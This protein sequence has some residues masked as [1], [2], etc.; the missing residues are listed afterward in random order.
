MPA[1]REYHWKLYDFGWQFKN[2]PGVETQ[3]E[4]GLARLNLCP[5]GHPDHTGTL[6]DLGC[7]L[8]FYYDQG[9]NILDLNRAIEIKQAR[10]DLCPLDHP[11]ALG[12]FALTLWS[13]YLVQRDVT[14]L[15]R[16]I[17]MEEKMFDLHPSGHP[18]HDT[19]LANLASYLNGHYQKQGNLT[20]LSRAIGLNE[21]CLELCPLSHQDH[22]LVLY[23]LESTL[24]NHYNEVQKHS[25]L[26]RAIKMLKEALATYPVQH[27]SFASIAGELAAA[28]LLPFKS[29]LPDQPLPLDEA[30]ENYRLLKKCGPAVSLDLWDA[31]QAWVKD[32]EEHNHSSVL[33]AYQTS[34]NTL[35][36]FTSFNSF[37]D[38]RHETMQARM[39]DL[40][41]NAFSCA[42]RHGDFQMAIELLEQGRGILGNQLAH[43]DFSITALQSWGNRGR[44]LGRKYMRLSADLRKRA[45]GSGG[46]GIDPY[47]RVQEE[48]QSVV[49]EIQRL[50]GFSRFLLPPRFEDLQDAA[51]YGPVIIANVSEY[52]CNA[53]IV[54]RPGPPVHVSLPCSFDDVIQLCSDLSTLTQD[55]HAYGDNR[56]S[57]IKQMLRERGVSKEV[58]LEKWI[59]FVHIGIWG[60]QL[61][62]VSVL[63]IRVFRV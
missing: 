62:Q 10:L 46:E 52:A 39:A 53:V 30:F 47:W 41:N 3:I 43:F 44:E 6:D 36:H 12:T 28:I 57:W 34:L 29:S 25:D 63:L 13:N 5:L 38:S 55:S 45:E 61:K 22:G 48:W 60:I 4:L 8:D 49:D 14:D 9:G 51:E 21:K 42:T 54:L 24:I 1:L 2:V 17:E 7:S 59:V 18:R 58:S 56:G 19:A 33:E 27:S 32:A 37:L 15:N 40:A 16:T 35:D 11:R 26:I 50:D 20:D 31:A 23:N